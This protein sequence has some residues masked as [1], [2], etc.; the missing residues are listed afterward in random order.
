M[1]ITY[2]FSCIIGLAIVLTF[3]S[4]IKA[5]LY[6]RQQEPTIEERLAGL[7][8]L[9]IEDKEKE[10]NSKDES[11]SFIPQPDL[12][13][14]QK[15][16]V[17]LSVIEKIGQFEIFTPTVDIFKW[18]FLAQ[19]CETVLITS[20]A[21]YVSEVTCKKGIDSAIKSMKSLSDTHNPYI[22]GHSDE[23]GYSFIL[24]AGNGKIIGEGAM[25]ET[26]EE[27]DAAVQNA[28]IASNIV[29]SN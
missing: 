11:T 18:R 9:E 5:A 29:V 6:R 16:W 3:G 12:I 4:E 1:D 13:D 14:I 2:I 21:D 7:P 26:K 23:L 28:V 24:K 15:S 22:V 25:F 20:T 19:D 10:T 27:C 17:P 8:R